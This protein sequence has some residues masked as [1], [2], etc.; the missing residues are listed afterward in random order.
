MLGAVD[1]RRI[2]EPGIQRTC[3]GEHPIEPF[4]LFELLK[5]CHPASFWVVCGG[6][7]GPGAR[8]MHPDW[9]RSLRDQCKASGVAFFFK[10]WGRYAPGSALDFEKNIVVLKN[11][12]VM[13]YSN[14]NWRIAAAK[15]AEKEWGENKPNA[16][17]TPFKNKRHR[18]ELD[19][20]LHREWPEVATKAQPA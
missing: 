7:S 11:G 4:D 6:E 19:G 17:H 3:K 16:M 15:Y 9:A 1:L 20:V 8:P 2:V 14:P 13:P 5:G 10:Q 12:E 18:A